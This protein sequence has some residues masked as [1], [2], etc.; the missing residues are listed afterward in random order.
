MED[1]KKVL[2]PTQI[3]N[4]VKGVFPLTV[5]EGE[6][7][8]TWIRDYGDQQFKEGIKSANNFDKHLKNDGKDS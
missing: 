5:I 2:T 6:I 3:V 7:L 4:R 8:E 1:E